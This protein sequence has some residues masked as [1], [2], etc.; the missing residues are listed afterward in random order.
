M[1]YRFIRQVARF[2]V[3]L[4]NGNARYTNKER[5]SKEEAYILVGPHRTWFDPIYF[6]L[7]GTPTIFSFMA[8]QELFKNPI[9]R[10]IL[11]HANAFPVD[12]E[13]PG[14]SVI[15][16]PVKFLKEGNLSLIMFPSGTRHSNDLKGGAATIAKLSGA[17]IVP[18]V[19]QGPLTIKGLL[20]RKRVTVNFGEPIYLDKKVKLTKETL[21]DIEDQ[22]Q[23]AFDQLD[24]EIDP[25]Y[26]YEAK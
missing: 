8:K 20:S 1:F 10:W 5:L 18:A 26:K 4:L 15:K 21:K 9:L 24:A 13:N 6:A 2:V 22:M 23:A 25:N 11:V 19:F 3:F 12:R 14:P 16:K 7:A 17:P